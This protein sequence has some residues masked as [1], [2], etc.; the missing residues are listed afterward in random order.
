MVD[1]IGIPRLKGLRLERVTGD[2]FIER[3]RAGVNKAVRHVRNAAKHYRTA[4]SL[5]VDAGSNLESARTH[6]LL[7]D[8]LQ[9]LGKDSDAVRERQTAQ[10]ILEFSQ[11][12]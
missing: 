6:E 7:A 5:Y 9:L 2:L 11:F 4:I 3:Y 1:E 10:E 8:A 12:E